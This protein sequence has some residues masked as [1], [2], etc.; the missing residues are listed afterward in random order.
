MCFVGGCTLFVFYVLL[1][2]GC[3]GGGF[4][5]VGGGWCD[6]LVVCI[7]GLVDSCVLGVFNACWC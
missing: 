3:C 2:R 1:C 6:S 7:I 5:L 4:A